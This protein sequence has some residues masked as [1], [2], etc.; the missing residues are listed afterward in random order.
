MPRRIP[1]AYFITFTSYGT[2]LH[3]DIRTWVDREHNEFGTE[4]LTHNPLLHAIRRRGL[5]HPAVTLSA[6]MIDAVLQAIRE[7]CDHRG[8]TL[9]RVNVRTNHVHALVQA[10]AE[11][12]KLLGDFKRYATRRLRV[13][14]LIEPDRPVWTDGG[15]TIYVWDR[16]SFNRIDR[17]IRYGQGENLGGLAG[18]DA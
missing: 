8:W 6:P 17:Y 4:R 5:K 18:H 13:E 12:E 9:V 14:E 7:V 15:S 16:E 1:F 10:N 2:W 3:G 11:A